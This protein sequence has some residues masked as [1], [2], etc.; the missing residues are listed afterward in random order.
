MRI[1]DAI[2]AR[3][4]A[5]GRSDPDGSIITDCPVCALEGK[6]HDKVRIAPDGRF[7]CYRY[8]GMGEAL[9]EHRRQMLGAWGAE[10]GD[11]KTAPA[12][13]TET[14]LD[15]RVTLEVERDRAG[16]YL[17]TAR[18]CDSVLQSDRLDLSDM[19][20]RARFVAS[21]ALAD[22]ERQIVLQALIQMADRARRVRAALD[23]ERGEHVR[24]T[25][26]S[27]LVDLAAGT[28]L[29][30]TPD[31][32]AFATVPVG[33][34]F[35]THPVKAKGFRR[36]LARRYY[37]ET[38]S[39]PPSQAMQDALGVLEGKAL[40][41]GAE[42]EVFLRSALHGGKIYL[43]LGDDLWRAV[44]IA[45]SGWRILNVPPVR[46]RRPR[47]ML[48]LPLPERGGTL[49]ELRPFLNCGSEADWILTLAWLVASLR[50]HRP[51]PIYI[52]HGEQG[53]GKSTRTR[54]LRALIDPNTAALR[55]E[56][57][58]EQDLVIAAKNGWII[59]HDNL[60][61]LP[62]W[63]SD[64]YCRISTGGGFAT[65]ELYTDADEVLFDATRPIILNGIEEIA[66]RNDLLDRAIITYLPQIPDP[67]RQTE[68]EFWQRFEAARPR[69][70]GALCDAVS[71][72]LRRLA[73]VKLARLPR[74]ADFARWATAVEPALGLEPGAVVRAY[75]ENRTQANEL[76]L[77][78]S[79]VAQAVQT[80]VRVEGQWKGTASQLLDDLNR[81]AT[82]GQRAAQGWPKAGR[83]LANTLRRL[84]PNLRAAG[85]A[86]SFSRES[87]TGGRRIIGLEDV[88][89]PSSPSSPSLPPN[90]NGP[91][92]ATIENELSSQ[93]DWL[94]SQSLAAGASSS[95]GCDDATIDCDDSQNLIVA[96]IANKYGPCDDGDDGD[97]DFLACSSARDLETETV[98]EMPRAQDT[99]PVSGG[100]VALDTETEPFDPVRT[101]RQQPAR[102][103]G[104]ALSYDGQRADYVTDPTRWPRMMPGRD[105]TVIFHNAKFD[106][107]VLDRA[108]LMRP[109]RWEDTLIAAHLLDENGEHG[110]K[111]LARKHLGIDDTDTFAEANRWRLIDPERFGEYARNDSRYTYRL[112]QIFEPELE[113]QDLIRVY[114]L[115]KSLVP[116]VIDMES[117]G[118][119]LDV[120]ALSLLGA[121]VKAEQ[122]RVQ[123]K[124]YDLAGCR[125][126]LGAPR[127]VAAILYDKLG[128]RCPKQT[129]TGSRS[130]DHEVLKEIAVLHPAAAALLE[131]RTLDKLASTFIEALPGYADSA[132]RVRAEYDQLGAKS[133]R[134]SAR[135]PNLQQVPARSELGKRLR[136]CFVAAHGCKLIV[137]DYSQMELRILAHYSKDPLLLEAYTAA[138][139]VDLHAATAARMFGKP[140]DQISGGERAIAKMINFGLAYGISAQGLSNRLKAQGLNM[141]EEQCEHSIASY[142]ATYSK[143]AAFLQS[144][145]QAIK[146]RGYVRSLYGR[147]R[148]LSGQTRREVR[149]AQN[150]IIQATAADLCK[151][152]MVSLHAALPAEA[153]IVAMVH[154]ELVIECRQEQAEEVR[155]LTVEMMSRRPAGFSVPL[156]VDASIVD[157]W[158]D[159]KE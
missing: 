62:V 136:A 86:V 65:R 34:H 98:P 106:L 90:K 159:A 17:V 129:R 20:A 120:A 93:A 23:P 36:W 27:R 158:S 96:K 84:A 100:L 72:A 44:E 141:T 53:S 5:I 97:D 128:L 137:A 59:A 114:A 145:E 69:I 30:H 78:A 39:A 66:T 37:R 10:A 124:V 113:R 148:R 28:D 109:E 92:E 134:F 19:R 89:N 54:V 47:G 115:E 31:G 95:E 14:I 67:S 22:D 147:R 8:A 132:G 82:E 55:S 49:D 24:K 58:D 35:E 71:V 81:T 3:L 2:R 102:M 40:F 117:A 26:A 74:M 87:G 41:D 140:V 121:F 48:A 73:T 15:G 85:V 79:P 9:M 133:G 130:V 103:I 119:Q 131:Y 99:L 149:Q 110:L 32:E 104:L 111:P 4:R 143:V 155:A 64:A 46:F 108:G 151:Q 80:L 105:Q 107:G 33:S 52:L 12:L 11:C 144:V 13:I 38:A 94:S 76:T 150:F 112:W 142:F 83:T 139:A 135:H 21:L 156:K 91:S 25:I 61:R 42:R 101:G 45:A 77:E 123:Q 57:R 43:D 1:P 126:D 60:S 29:F 125:F 7:T 16:R 116:V 6:G 51:F 127:K 88:R 56:P 152:A 18:N 153:A 70:L 50:P 63:L 68:D 118:M 146:Q 75:A 122:S 138:E 157:R 154:D